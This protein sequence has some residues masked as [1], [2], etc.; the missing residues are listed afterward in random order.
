MMALTLVGVLYLPGSF[1]SGIFGSNFFNYSPG[2]DGR[3]DW[4]M[5]SKFWIYWAVTIPLTIVTFLSLI[6]PNYM[7]ELGGRAVAVVKS[8]RVW[9]FV[10]SAASSPRQARDHTETN[11]RQV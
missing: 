3:P 5:S 7:M 1:I 8:S 10:S 2:S 11:M 4:N 9:G 6:M